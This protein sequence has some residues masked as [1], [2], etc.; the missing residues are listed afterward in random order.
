M[1]VKDVVCVVS[2][3][4]VVKFNVIVKVDD[5]ENLMLF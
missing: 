2:V 5:V 4:D 1:S 3:D